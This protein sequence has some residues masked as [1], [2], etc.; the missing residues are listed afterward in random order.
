IMRAVFE[1]KEGIKLRNPSAIRPWQHVLD[2][3]F[4]Y[5]LLAERLF[6]GET[7]AA[8]AWNFAPDKGNFVTVEELAKRSIKFLG[9]GSYSIQ[10][11]V[12][13]HET[14]V[15]RLDAAKA[16]T[17]LGWKPL[18]GIDECVEWTAGWYKDFYTGKDARSV[19]RRQFD[20]YLEKAQC[21]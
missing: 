13:K 5:L 2:P 18:L 19:T 16:R 6:E 9:T 21:S 12:G 20:S 1:R 7:N 14:A 15:L 11:E 4:G 17:N 10:P 8:G 3:L